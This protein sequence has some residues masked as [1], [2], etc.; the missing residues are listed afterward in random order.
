MDRSRSLGSNPRKSLLFD[1]GHNH[2]VALRPSSI[3]NKKRQRPVTSNE[4]EFLS[5]PHYL[6]TPRSD[7]SI[8]RISIETSSPISASAFNFSSACEVFSFDAS[9]TRYARW[10]FLMRSFVKPRSSNPHALKH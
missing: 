6:I 8:N 10:I 9:S 7:A 4:A 5:A 1:R 3:Q 2:V